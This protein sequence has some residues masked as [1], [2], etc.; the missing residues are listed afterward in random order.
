MDHLL[1]FQFLSLR[2]F[3]LLPPTLARYEL[4]SLVAATVLHRTNLCISI[5]DLREGLVLIKLL[6]S[7]IFLYQHLITQVINAL[8]S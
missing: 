7:H 4:G 2:G 1:I 5:L 3:T 8:E 6:R